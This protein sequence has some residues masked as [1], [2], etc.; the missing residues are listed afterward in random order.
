MAQTESAAQPVRLGLVAN[1]RQF[2]LLLIVNACVGGMVGLERTVV[3]L[4]G[5]REFH[6]A[7][8]ALITSFIVSFGIA[9]ALTNLISGSFADRFGRKPVLI[10][11]WLIG[12]PVPALIIVAPSWDWIVA[13][14]VLLGVNQGLAW[15]MTVNMKIDLVGPARRG[16][17]LGLNEFSGYAA[18]GLTA[19]LTGLIASRYGLGRRL[20]IWV[21]FTPPP[22]SCFLSSWCATP[23]RMS[24]SKGGFIR[25][26][27]RPQ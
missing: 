19:F 27:V 14:N 10:A 12:L 7:D 24:R 21:S 5:A 3:P 23:A 22:A 25:R 2:A 15:S 16:L 9:K 20:S 4:I 8:T 17:A 13:A 6:L 26:R 1:W 18:V 11:G